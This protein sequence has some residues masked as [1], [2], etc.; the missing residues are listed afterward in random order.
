LEIRSNLQ[1]MT[2]A[3]VLKSVETAREE[4]PTSRNPR[5][6]EGTVRALLATDLVTAPTRK[7]LQ[8]RLDLPAVDAPRWFSADECATLAAV[9]ARLIP[10]TDRTEIVDV[11]GLIDQ[12]LAEGPGDG[13]RYAEMPPDGKAH[14]QGLR[15]LDETSEIW[16]GSTFK[17]LEGVCQDT[18]LTTVQRGAPPGKIWRTLSARRYFE[19]LL[20]IAVDVYYAHPF[21]QEEIGYVGMADARGWQAI[22][23][24]ERAAHEPLPVANAQTEA[25]HV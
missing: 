15:G 23:L 18:V 4:V 12:R 25:A 10:Q 7:A 3:I 5:W 20:A 17:L 2:M 13:W 19:E 22:R 16:F 24:N 9:C 6:P 14:R 11:P 1:E 8:A 21:A